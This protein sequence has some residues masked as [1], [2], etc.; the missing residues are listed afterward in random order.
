MQ[1]HARSM[2][3]PSSY[4][5]K[6]PSVFAKERMQK[7]FSMF[8]VSTREHARQRQGFEESRGAM[9]TVSQNERKQRRDENRQPKILKKAEAR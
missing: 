3:V 6:A 1:S 8:L 4:S 7:L 2:Q 9:K 5:V